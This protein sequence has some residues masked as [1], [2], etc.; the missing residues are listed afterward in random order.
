MVS[1]LCLLILYFQG[2]NSLKDFFPTM[3]MRPNP[4]CSNGAC[5][6]R[7]VIPQTWRTLS[8]SLSLSLISS[9]YFPYLC[10]SLYCL[11]T[12][13]CILI[14]FLL[15]DSQH[16]YIYIYIYISLSLTTHPVLL[17]LSP[18]PSLSLL[19]ICAPLHLY[20]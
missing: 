2:Y 8:L 17:R 3:E 14:Y 9:P 15:L 7:Q 16:I 5:L 20:I 11:V 13:R 1:L 19:C 4:Q 12:H 10:L 18:P 6:E